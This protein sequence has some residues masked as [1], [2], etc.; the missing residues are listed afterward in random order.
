[1]CTILICVINCLDLLIT[2]MLQI[3]NIGRVPKDESDDAKRSSPKQNDLSC[4]KQQVK[5][6][7]ILIK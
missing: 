1:M 3:G 2:Y 7:I 6:Q 5:S 4:N